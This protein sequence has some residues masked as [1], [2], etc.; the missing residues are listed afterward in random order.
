MF[1]K[2][3]WHKYNQQ[4]VAQTLKISLLYIIYYTE[5]NTTVTLIDFS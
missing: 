4:N 2:T 3:V 1:A 5:C